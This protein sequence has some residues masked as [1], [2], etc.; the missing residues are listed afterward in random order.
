MMN[1]MSSAPLTRLNGPTTLETVV[2]DE[3][4]HYTSSPNNVIIKNGI[5]RIMAKKTPG[6]SVPYTSTRM[7]TRGLKSFRY[8]RIRFRAR[9]ANCTARGTW[10]ALWMLPEKWVY[11]E[12]IRDDSH[13]LLCSFTQT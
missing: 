10:P 3:Q 8:G 9:L 5:L 11:G 1:S 13:F 4:Q 6:Y 12:S 2:G 7:V